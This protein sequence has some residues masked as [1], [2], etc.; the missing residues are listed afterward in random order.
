MSE[1]ATV[2]IFLSAAAFGVC[3]ILKLI[4]LLLTVA[5][6]RHKNVMK[7]IRVYVQHTVAF[8]FCFAL[9][10]LNAEAKHRGQLC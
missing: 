6:M 8:F 2:H 10:L 4:R 3:V 7:N 5:G 1:S 9:V